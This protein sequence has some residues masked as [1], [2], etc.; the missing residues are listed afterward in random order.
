M[1]LLD[2]YVYKKFI[3]YEFSL[4]ILFSILVVASQVMHLPSVFYH[5]GIFQF[6][7]SLLLINISFFK[8]QYFIATTL[9]FFFT[10]INLKETREIIAIKSIGISK[11]YLLSLIFKISIVLAL[12][13]I[14]FSFFIIPKANRER[15]K[16]ITKSVRNYYM[17]SVQPKNFFKFPG[18]SVIYIEDKNKN[19]F[20]DI[21]LFSKKDGRL[22]TA[23]N[24][25]IKNGL[26]ILENGLM[27]IPSKKGFSVLKFEKYEFKL[28]INYKKDYTYDDFELKKLIELTLSPNKNEK[29]KAYS[30]IFERIGYVIPFFFF[31]IIAFFIGIGIEKD[32]E[33]LLGGIILFTILYI[34]VNFYL[35]KLIEKGY[36]NSLVYLVIISLIMYVSAI[37]SYKKG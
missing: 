7:L 37:Y 35:L 21:F 33:I 9:A 27:Q 32:K 34:F 6:I 31:G 5:I 19:Q 30:I 17:E 23:K 15:V 28:Y 20:I 14:L 3:A 29:N 24:A 26:L 18:D 36:L 12:L 25:F 4:I 13:S 22:I 11:K 1:K 16:F 8:L 2:K 10:G